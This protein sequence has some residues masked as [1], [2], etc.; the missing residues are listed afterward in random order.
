MRCLY[1]VS[2]VLGRHRLACVQFASQSS[3]AH[4]CVD[5]FATRWHPKI[6]QSNQSALAAQSSSMLPVK[7]VD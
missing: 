3:G 5:C 1:A 7:P 2:T 4:M 6:A